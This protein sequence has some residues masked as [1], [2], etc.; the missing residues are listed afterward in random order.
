M[1]SLL[2]K[3]PNCTFRP[4]LSFPIAT[5]VSE[6]PKG[7]KPTTEGCFIGSARSCP[8][9]SVSSPLRIL[10][11]LL[12]AVGHHLAGGC[13][14][15]LLHL[16]WRLWRTRRCPP[17]IIRSGQCE[18]RGNQRGVRPIHSNVLSSSAT[19]SRKNHRKARLS[20]RGSERIML[21][22]CSSVS[23]SGTAGLPA[24]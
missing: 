5:V 11:E 2:L 21:Q 3:E 15:L 1:S 14:V 19:T 12:F 10:T 22:S 4:E 18:V 23:H 24:R 20:W 8:S 17:T 16:F 6:A 9:V 7:R 13:P